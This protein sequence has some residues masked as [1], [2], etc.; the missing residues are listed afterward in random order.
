MT[1]VEQ[2]TKYFAP[3]DEIAE[4]LNNNEGICG[5]T[6]IELKLVVENNSE[7]AADIKAYG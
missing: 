2:C 6:N 3:I 5:A 4:A 1:Y 7:L